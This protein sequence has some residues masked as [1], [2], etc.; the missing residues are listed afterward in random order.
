MGSLLER[1]KAVATS[2]ET[3]RQETPFET[4]VGQPIPQLD[5]ERLSAGRPATEPKPAASA[6]KPPE[7]P[8]EDEH[9]TTGRLLAM[10]RRRRESDDSE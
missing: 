3:R 6:E 2:L 9:S 8:T 4:P 7:P 10:K 1:K 5:R